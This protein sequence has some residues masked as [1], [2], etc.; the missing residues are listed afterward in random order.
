MSAEHQVS[1]SLYVRRQSKFH[2][3]YA[4]ELARQEKGVTGKR[5][6]GEN[7]EQILAKGTKV[8]EG[9]YRVERGYPA[10]VIDLTGGGRGWGSKQLG[11]SQ[12]LEVLTRGL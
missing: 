8:G 10:G 1:F 3:K 4:Y 12:L 2:W 5:C 6:S 7:G 9:T 11:S